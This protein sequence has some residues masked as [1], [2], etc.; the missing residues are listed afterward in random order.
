MGEPK[1][2]P[3]ER[4]DVWND[5]MDFVALVYQLTQSFPP[6]E[7]FGLTSQVRRAAVSVASNIAEGAARRSRKEY[8][9]HLSMARGSLAEADTQW[10][11]ALRLGFVKQ[12]ASWEPFINTL[13]A[14]LT[15]LMNALTKASTQE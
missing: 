9:R 10:K 4:L 6:D 3:H 2:R 5:S 15:A 1:L 12:N 14:R 8:V 13:F 7:K 11:I